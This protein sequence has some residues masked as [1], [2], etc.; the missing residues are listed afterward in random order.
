NPQAV[1]VAHALGPV[2]AGTKV[3][4]EYDPM[5]G[6]IDAR[7]REFRRVGFRGKSPCKLNQVGNGAVTAKFVDRRTVD[8]AIDG[9][10]RPYWRDKDHVT[11]QKSDGVARVPANKH[12]VKI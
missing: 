1:A 2:R 8:F 12:V 5:Q 7:Q 9:D 6:G 3:D 10:R 11:W 4:L